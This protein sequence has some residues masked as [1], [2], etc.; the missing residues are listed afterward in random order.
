MEAP[1]R[2][3]IRAIRDFRL[4]LDESI[5]IIARQ[6]LSAPPGDRYSY[7]GAG[8]MLVGAM[9][10]KASGRPFEQLL[11]DNLCIPLEM[12]ATSYFPGDQ[13]TVRV[14]VGGDSGMQPPHRLGVRHRLPLIGGSL[15]STSSDAE[16]FIR[17]LLGGKPAVLSDRARG[18]LLSPAFSTQD[19]GFGWRLVRENGRVVRLIHRGSLPPY[20]A[21]FQ[22]NLQQAS[23]AIV[24]WTLGRPEN[25]SVT[26]RIQD[27]VSGVFA[28]R[29]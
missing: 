4:S 16:S 21:F 24:L 26:K 9:A 8:Y 20:Q 3:Q 25:G 10:E 13:T 23:Y 7:S 27:G 5:G 2:D 1:T 28:G 12:K 14:A 11:Q 22:I 15:Y 19:Y 29:S 6:P 18:V 17:M